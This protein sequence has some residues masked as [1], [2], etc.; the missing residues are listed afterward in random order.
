MHAKF[1]VAD[2][3]RG[4]LG[5]ANLTSFGLTQHVEVGVGLTAPQAQELLRLI[6]GLVAAGFF[7]R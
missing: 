6:D 7:L 1:V 3:R 5:S 2:G 4:Y